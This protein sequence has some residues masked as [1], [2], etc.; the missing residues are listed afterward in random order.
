[1]C[2]EDLNEGDLE[3]GD[4]AVHEDACQVQLHLE[5]H[6]HIR[7]VDGWTPPQGKAT[8]RDLIET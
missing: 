6:V 7:P 5:T 4:F 1:M 2:P 3:C 8:V